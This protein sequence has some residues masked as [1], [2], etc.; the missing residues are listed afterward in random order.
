MKVAILIAKVGSIRSIFKDRRNLFFER[1]SHF[2]FSIYFFSLGLE[3]DPFSVFDPP[4]NDGYIAYAGM[5]S[6]LI[7]TASCQKVLVNRKVGLLAENSVRAH[8]GFGM[9]L[10]A[11]GSPLLTRLTTE[12]KLSKTAV[13]QTAIHAGIFSDMIA[14]S[15]M[16]IGDLIF[17]DDSMLGDSEQW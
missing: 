7:V 14:T 16:C 2:I 10:A 9:V 11:T 12:L 4:G 5:L 13:G 8:L 3:M 15:L 1:A 6:T 17:H